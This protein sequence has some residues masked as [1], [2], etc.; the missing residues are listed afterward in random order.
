LGAASVLSGPFTSN[1]C[2]HDATPRPECR[3][4][5]RMHHLLTIAS[6]EFETATLGRRWLP[7]E[8]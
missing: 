5:L 2:S 1:G 7:L 8:D 4:G 3:C 6:D